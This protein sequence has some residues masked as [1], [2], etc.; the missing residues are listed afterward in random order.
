MSFINKNIEVVV[1]TGL[2]KYQEDWALVYLEPNNQYSDCGGRLTVNINDDYVG[3]H[4]FSHCGG[5]SFKAFVGRCGHDY[6]IGKLFKTDHDMELETGE[7]IIKFIFNHPDL[8]AT[9]KE[10]RATDMLTKEQLRGLYDN[11]QN[12]E[13]GGANRIAED[14]TQSE[15][16]I[17]A[18]VFGDDWY[19]GGLFSTPNPLY[20]HHA[21]IMKS[22]IEACREAVKEDAPV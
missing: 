15:F 22:V 6:L 4:F 17:A 3:S 16:N 13:H 2:G 21:D 12:C 5:D 20:A 14:M 1:L 11:I 8:K 9:I 10:Q 19:W 7:E 18:Q